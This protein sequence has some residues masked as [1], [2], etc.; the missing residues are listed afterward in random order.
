[1]HNV[2]SIHL[3][4]YVNSG[5]CGT[6]L[7]S[8]MML[9]SLRNSRTICSTERDCCC[10]PPRSRAKEQPLYTVTLLRCRR[11]INLGGDR[12]LDSQLSRKINGVSLDEDAGPLLGTAGTRLRRRARGEGRRALRHRLARSAGLR[13][14]QRKAWP[15]FASAC[16]TRTNWFIITFSEI[17]LRKFEE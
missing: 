1:M 17:A 16:T 10:L 13:Q 7:S 6:H 8:E 4:P 14:R 11:Q 3:V 15:V 12:P 5:S 2:Y 9:G